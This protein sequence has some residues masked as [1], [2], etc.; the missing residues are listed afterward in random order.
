M[1]FKTKYMISKS[2]ITAIMLCLL[3]ASFIFGQQLKIEKLKGTSSSNAGSNYAVFYSTGMPESAVWPLGMKLL[4][5]GRTIRH[6]EEYAIGD[7]ISVNDKVPFRFIIAPEN[8]SITQSNGDWAWAMGFTA[9]ANSNSNPDGIA[10]D[11][12][13]CFKY[14]TDQFPDG[15]RLPTQRE[16]MLMWLFREGI[17]AIY[18]SD[19]FTGKKYW[20]ATERK[21]GTGAYYMLF[22][23]D[24]PELKSQ[25]KTSN[26][27]NAVR[28][29]RDY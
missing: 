29:V 21:N 3:P 24:Y 26:E 28:C 10:D 6:F 5:N 9:D 20:S 11:Q 18:N 16:L 27:S 25:A 2:F 15:W 8:L 13:G 1:N 7:N 17:N 12:A 19:P 14:S 4:K 22:D 23:A